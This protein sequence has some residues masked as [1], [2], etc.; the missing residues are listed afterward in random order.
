MGGYCD[1]SSLEIILVT[2]DQPS[3]TAWVLR[4]LVGKVY[5]LCRVKSIWIAVSAVIGHAMSRSQWLGNLNTWCVNKG[6]VRPW[7][8]NRWHCAGQRACQLL[9]LGNWWD[10]SILP[11]GQ[12][13]KYDKYL[14]TKWVSQSFALKVLYNWTLHKWLFCKTINLTAWSLINHMHL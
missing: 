11:Q 1:T 2:D 4:R 7:F 10:G 13:L 6:G 5:N 9:K 8:W 12:Q 14:I 3:A